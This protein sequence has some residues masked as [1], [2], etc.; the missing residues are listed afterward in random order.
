MVKNLSLTTGQVA[1]AIGTCPTA[2]SR[3][4]AAVEDLLDG[5]IREARRLTRTGRRDR[6]R[7]LVVERLRVVALL[8]SKHPE[9]LTDW[10]DRLM[11]AQT[12]RKAVR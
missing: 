8:A 11:V 2:S 3:Q 10:I 5:C 1:R 9:Q 4:V 12:N 6:V 7:S